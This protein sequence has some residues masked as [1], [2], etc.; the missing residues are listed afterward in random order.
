MRKIVT[1]MVGAGLV[2]GA[3]VSASA[4]E[5]ANP[6]VG[7]SARIGVFLPTEDSTR[8][9]ASDSWFAAGVDFKLKDLATMGGPGSFTVSLDYAAK[10]DFRLLPILLNYQVRQGSSYLFGGVGATFSRLGNGNSDTL[11]A[12]QI[13]VGYDYQAGATPLFVEGKF[14]GTEK[15]ELNGFGVYVG[16][17]F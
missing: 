7:L 17:R 10:N 15:S 4:Q 12:Y 6:P 13:G 8:D 1:T 9:V 5:A 3:A 14:M 16:V 11:F 2:F